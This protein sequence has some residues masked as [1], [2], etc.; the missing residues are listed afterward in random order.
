MRKLENLKKYI[1]NLLKLIKRKIFKFTID[2]F[3]ELNPFSQI[4]EAVAQI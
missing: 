4:G 3:Y 1:L 2:K